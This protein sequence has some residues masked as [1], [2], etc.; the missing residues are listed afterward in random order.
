[1]IL[2]VDEAFMEDILF[3]FSLNK[4]QAELLALSFPLNSAWT[5]HVLDK[6]I[7]DEIREQLILLRGDFSEENQNQIL[8]NYQ[9]MKS[10]ANLQRVEESEE[11]ADDAN[12]NSLSI[13]CD[14]A[15]SNNPGEAG[16]GIA[17]YYPG[18]KPTLL[19]GAFHILGTNNTAELNA[20][21]KALKI[22]AVEKDNFSKITIYSDSQYSID[23]ISKWA[24]SWKK[25]N[26]TKKG[27]EIKNLEKIQ[28]THALYEE[29]KEFVVVKHIK[30]HS[31]EE[32]NEL[33]DRMALF[34]ISSQ[35]KSYTEF[36]YNSVKEIL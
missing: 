9:L 7:S 4:A 16:S 35:T 34:A 32:G 14:G 5:S 6:K 20:L 3:N 33:A 24:Y 26:W 18:K 10:S 29:I 36:N 31:G 27:G 21:Q 8:L 2:I 15:C 17:I 13:Y 28:A 19:Y 30:G 22:A 12:M 11:F 23:C 25:N 1:M